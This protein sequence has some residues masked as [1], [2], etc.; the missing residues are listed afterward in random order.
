MSLL[1]RTIFRAVTVVCLIL[2]SSCASV[3]EDK[4][5]DWTEEQLYY[6]GKS[7]M[8]GKFYDRA[9]L[10]YEKLNIRYPFGIY[11]LQAKIDIAYVY[12]KKGD[13]VKALAACERFLREH[14]DHL[15]V[16]YVYYLKAL[17]FF[18]DDPGLKGLVS[19]KDLTVL[20]PDRIKEAFFTLKDLV[21]RFPGSKYAPDSISRM[22]YLM[23]V[24]ALHELNIADHYY[25][26][27]AY[28]GA[29]NRAKFILSEYPESAHTLEALV[30]MSNSYE[31]LGLQ[32]L[33]DSTDE[34]IAI[35]FP[36]ELEGATA[37]A[38][39][40]WFDRFFSGGSDEEGRK[41]PWWK[42]WERDSKTD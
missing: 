9:I 17:I 30:M 18:N 40:A 12:W 3:D 27:G 26:V 38:D 5:K 25:R 24:L 35:N 21:T 6:A 34:I 4:T 33:K 14:P 32:A 28:V 13:E 19:N 15:N 29:V 31:K 20:D 11:S 36:S 23:N 8:D 7:D 42:F 22:R 41:L 10:T 16:D 39:Q 1:F 2:L 37:E